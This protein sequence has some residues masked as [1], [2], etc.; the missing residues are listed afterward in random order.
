M[1]Y[2]LSFVS[3]FTGSNVPAAAITMGIS[4]Y[5]DV[6]NFVKGDIDVKEF[7]YNIG[8]NTSRIVGGFT[9]A[10]VF[11][12][13]G[14]VGWAAGGALFS[15]IAVQEY[16]VHVKMI[17]NTFNS[18]IDNQGDIVAATKELASDFK[19]FASQKLYDI[20]DN[21]SNFKDIATDF[22]DTAGDKLDDLKDVA[23]NKFGDLK[24]GATDKLGSAKSGAVKLLKKIK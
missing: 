12:A 18:V 4:S 16:K 17:S 8:E 5:C 10:L 9:G 6:K 19:G 23:V 2:C 3:T 7:A 11:A 21:A 14:P 13:T 1:G 20:K 24:D 22:K 15:Q